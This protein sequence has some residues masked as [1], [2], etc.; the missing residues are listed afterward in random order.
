MKIICLTGFPSG[1]AKKWG[2]IMRLTL[3]LMVGLLFTASASS[4]S[5]NTRLD[6]KLKN[7]TVTD[8]MKYVE[9][10]SEFVFLY[11]NEDVDMKKKL[12]VELEDATIQ[13]VLE[14]A[15][16]EQ[17]LEWDVYDRQIVLRKST[18]LSGCSLPSHS[19]QLRGR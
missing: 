1:K 19:A 6:I 18:Q 13:Q 4:Y 15:F 8:L 11:K 2:R 7:G 17:N 5:Q 14:T 3:F 9:D 16:R 10:N 12:D